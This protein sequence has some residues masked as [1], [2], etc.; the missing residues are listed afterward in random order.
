MSHRVYVYYNLDEIIEEL[1]LPKNI[2]Y[3]IDSNKIL[4]FFYKDYCVAEFTN[5]GSFSVLIEKILNSK[6][7]GEDSIPL[8]TLSL[9]YNKVGLLLL[10]LNEKIISKEELESDILINHNKVINE[11]SE[12]NDFL[13]YYRKVGTDIHEQIRFLLSCYNGFYIKVK[14]KTWREIRD[15]LYYEILNK[16]IK[17]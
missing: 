15:Y 14:T 7:E 10:E 12:M 16:W 11:F 5:N 13:S 6:R 2:D 8:Y 4:K 3:D 1:K 17:Y 9:M